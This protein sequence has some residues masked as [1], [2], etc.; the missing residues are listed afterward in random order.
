MGIRIDQVNLNSFA[1]VFPLKS[2]V[3]N[4][5]QENLTG[6]DSIEIVPIID[7]VSNNTSSVTFNVKP[8]TESTVG[9]VKEGENINIS[10]DGTISVPT[11]TE[12]TLGVVS[13]GSNL[14]L[15]GGHINVNIASA[16]Q[17]GIVQVGDN[18]DV[19]NGTISVPK[20]SSDQLGLVKIG[21]NIK[22]NQDGTIYV[23]DIKWDDATETTKGV[24]QVGDNI[25]VTEGVISVPVASS[26]QKG[27]VQVGNN[28]QTSNGV[29]S[30]ATGSKSQKGALQVGNNIDVTDGV[31]SVGSATKSQKGVVQVGNNIE[32]NNGTISVNVGSKTQKGVLGIGSNLK[33]ENGNVNVGIASKTE[34]GILQVGQ[35]LN[36]SNGVISSDVN[37]DYVDQKAAESIQRDQELEASIARLN[38]KVEEHETKITSLTNSVKLLQQYQLT[39]SAIIEELETRITLLEK[40][41]SQEVLSIRPLLDRSFFIGSVTLNGHGNPTKV[42]LPDATFTNT[43]Y[44]VII[45]PN[46]A[47][48][49]NLGEYW[50]E[51]KTTS[52]FTVVNTGRAT[53]IRCDFLIMTAETFSKPYNASSFPYQKGTGQFNGSTGR[54]VTLGT[55]MPDANYVVMIMPCKKSTTNYGDLGEY[56]VSNKTTTGFKVFNSGADTVSSFD[57]IV[58]KTGTPTYNETTNPIIEGKSSFANAGKQ[59]TF[60]SGMTHTNYSVL[61]TPSENPGGDLGEYWV[62]N[63]STN[64]FTVAN[65]GSSTCKFDYIIVG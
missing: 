43:N 11:A 53:M 1:K 58:I 30:V 21:R 55:A 49:G 62:E 14:Y 35:N 7:P 17:K 46:S 25:D 57:Y 4:I 15:D 34:K 20:A 9:G 5:V 13:V 48:N 56:W 33:E 36:I 65:T 60:E 23:D 10:E 26:S 16:Q 50:I 22:Q 8:A 3:S 45:T 27:V 40:L 39:S 2:D 32:V 44:R 52:S 47:S 6:S 28:I 63:K 12:D 51:D 54:Q 38:T 42:T 19:E 59:V 24:V 31:I 61:I 41:V 37:K 29:I 64:T 18:I